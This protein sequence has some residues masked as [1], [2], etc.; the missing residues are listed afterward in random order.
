MSN[1][2]FASVWDAIDDTP[3]QAENMR[4]RSALVMAPKG[5]IASEGLSQ[6]PGRQGVRRHPAS[7]VRPHARQDRTVW[8]RHL[9]QYAGR[10]GPPRRSAC[11]Q[12]GLT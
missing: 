7:R 10:G 5:H 11:G 2:R 6:K 8:A 4:L 3:A 9:G 12:G 1:E